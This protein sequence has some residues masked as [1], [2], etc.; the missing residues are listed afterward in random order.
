M[1]G[2]VRGVGV[3]PGGVVPPG[4]G[5]W[6]ARFRGV[7]SVCCGPNVVKVL[8]FFM[9]TSVALISVAFPAPGGIG[10][11]F[12]TAF[13]TPGGIDPTPGALTYSAFPTPGGIDPAPGAL[14]NST[15]PAPGGIDPTPGASR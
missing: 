6:L 11:E 1:K 13:P 7:R 12:I 3:D 8:A 2:A 4:P 5:A 14:T 9:E 15:F 10:V